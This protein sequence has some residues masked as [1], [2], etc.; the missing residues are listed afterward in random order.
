MPYSA[1]GTHH[2]PKSLDSCQIS[3]GFPLSGGCMHDLIIETREHDLGGGFKVGRLLP[4]RK[5]RMVGPFIFFDRMGPHA[6]ARSE[7]RRVGKECVS[8]CRSRWSPYH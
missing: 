7:E 2:N 8:T 4:F 6:L 5:R 3:R 1:I